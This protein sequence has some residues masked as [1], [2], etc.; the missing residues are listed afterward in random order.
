MQCRLKS[1]KRS[2]THCLIENDRP[3]F[4]PEKHKNTSVLKTGEA[5]WVSARQLASKSAL[6]FAVRIGGAGVIFLAQAMIARLWG[7]A[8]LG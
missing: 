3:F 2:S 6:I 8:Q 5:E 4:H 1:A 7:A